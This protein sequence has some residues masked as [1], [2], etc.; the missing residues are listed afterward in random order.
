MQGCA[1]A[2]LH[3]FLLPGNHFPCPTASGEL[4]AQF[5]SWGPSS[6][7]STTGTVHSGAAPVYSSAGCWGDPRRTEKF[8]RAVAVSCFPGAGS[9]AEAMQGCC[10]KPRGVCAPSIWA[11]QG[12]QRSRDPAHRCRE[13][14][15]SCRG[16]H[17]FMFSRNTFF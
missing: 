6:V 14:R 3:L 7:Y 5:P 11:T 12:S 4:L 9:K 13:C 2:L 15:G 1:E 10:L 16:T 8:P 17:T